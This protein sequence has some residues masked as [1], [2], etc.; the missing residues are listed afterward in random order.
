M[1]SV[2]IPLYNKEVTIAVTLN[3]VLNQTFKDF[4]VIIINDGSTDDSLYVVNSF[5]D[6]RLYVSSQ[7]N[8]GV[9]QARNNAVLKARYDY[10]AFLDA[11]DYWAPNY[12]EEIAKLIKSYPQNHVFTTAYQVITR[13]RSFSQCERLQEG[14]IEDF[15]KTR[16][17]NHIMRTSAT[18]VHKIA[19]DAVGGFPP[20]MY[21]GEDDYTWAKIAIKYKIVFSPKVLA[22]YDNRNSSYHLRRGKLDTCKESWFD[23]YE[24]N[25]FY[26]NEFIASKAI[27]AGIR[28]AYGAPQLKS[29]EI[30]ERTRYTTLAKEK[31]KYLYILNRIPQPLILLVKKILPL[32]KRSKCWLARGKTM[33]YVANFYDSGSP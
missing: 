31:W 23:L 29:L 18:V 12:L 27:S 19:L 22:T 32:Y 13:N 1:F 6:P 25:N 7:E 10:L 4:E 26:R 9:S 2:I 8:A 16:A 15:F 33:A 20:G 11:D 30:E 28:Y 5:N 14:L 17:T 3:S 21:G 24:D